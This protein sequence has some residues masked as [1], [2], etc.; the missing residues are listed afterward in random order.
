MPPVPNRT[1]GATTPS[2]IF[3]HFFIE[4]ALGLPTSGDKTP[5]YQFFTTGARR[6]FPNLDAG[7]RIRTG[8]TGS[9]SRSLLLAPCYCH[10]WLQ[11]SAEG[12]LNERTILIRFCWER[13]RMYLRACRSGKVRE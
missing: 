2:V 9:S 4:L 8:E 13:N 10:S 11:T 12:A 7:L 3:C 5:R 6:M 1:T